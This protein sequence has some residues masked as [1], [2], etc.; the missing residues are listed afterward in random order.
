MEGQTRFYQLGWAGKE[1][2]TTAYYKAV[3]LELGGTWGG[4]MA[5]GWWHKQQSSSTM[6]TF[7]SLLSPVLPNFKLPG[8][9]KKFY[10]IS[11]LILKGGI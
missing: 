2:Q 9:K 7:V 10:F 1:H 11:F 4:R 3:T 8:K 6:L 5:N